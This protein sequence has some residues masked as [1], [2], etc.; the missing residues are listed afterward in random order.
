LNFSADFLYLK[1]TTLESELEETGRV[2]V[3]EDRDRYQGGGTLFYGLDELSKIN[4]GYQYWSTDYGSGERIDRVSHRVRFPYSRWF[5]DHLDQLILRPSY[6]K[7][8]TEDNR[9]IDYYNFSVGWMHIFN[10]TLSM[11]NFVG[12]GYTITTK[13]GDRE[14]IQS[15][16]VDLSITQTDEIFSFRVGFRS[17]IGLNADGEIDEVD[18]LYCRIKRK[19]SERLSASFNG[20]V[21]INRPTETYTSVD[22]VYYDIKPEL[23]YEI[24]EN[25]LLNVFYR[26]SY[27]EDQTVS[28]NQESIRNVIELNIVFQFPN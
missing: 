17:N 14:T 5:N 28:E 20:S 19:L 27:E 25:H 23:L 7:T 3:R 1:D 2:M 24:T 9:D 4:V 16:T 26:Y 8:E 18:R 12:Y 6:T 15:G 11:R 10:E 13:T 22:S 21:Y